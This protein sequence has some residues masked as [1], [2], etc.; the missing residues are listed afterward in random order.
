MRR[1][2]VIAA[3]SVACTGPSDPDRTAIATIGGEPV[4]QSDLEAHLRANILDEDD[5]RSGGRLD[6]VK[7]RLLD[8]LIDEQLLV[9]EARRIGLEVSEE[10]VEAALAEVVAE[11]PSLAVDSRRQTRRRLLL[12]KLEQTLVDRTALPSDVEVRAWLDARATEEAPERTVT[13]RSARFE[14]LERAREAVWRIENR[15]ESFLD[16]AASGEVAAPVELEESAVS[17]EVR[18]AID[19]LDL[20]GISE[21][22]TVHGGVFLFR[23]EDRGEGEVDRFARIEQARL[24]LAR[25]RVRSA[26]DSLLRE[27]RS[28][29]EVTIHEARLPFAY[30]APED[31]S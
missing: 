27:L 23:V 28:R 15:G 1:A 5:T 26:Q 11:P 29:T 2:I 21:P 16:A 25:E 20:G 6:R 31:A 8:A 10:E 17:P 4:T 30:S 19:G 22:V 7:S 24:E 18:A 14:T 13:I 9:H 12:R 3:L